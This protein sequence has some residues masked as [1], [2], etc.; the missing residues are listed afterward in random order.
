[1][2]R[3]KPPKLALR[4]LTIVLWLGSALPL[5]ANTSADQLYAVAA[6][7]YAQGEWESAAESFARFLSNQPADPRSPSAEYYRGECFVQLQH[8][9]EA[10]AIFERFLARHPEHPQVI[11][12]RFRAGEVAYRLGDQVKAERYLAEFR[13]ESAGHELEAFAVPH[14]AAMALERGDAARAAELYSFALQTFPRGPLAAECRLGVATAQEKLGNL[15][16]ARRFYRVAALSRDAAVATQAQLRLAI[17][18][19]REDNFLAALEL[20]E[21]LPEKINDPALLSHVALWK[22]RSLDGLGRVREAAE[23]WWEVVERRPDHEISESLAY[24]AAGA[25][26][27]VGDMPR[28]QQAYRWLSARNPTG[29]W[30]EESLVAQI[31]ILLESERLMPR[32]SEVERNRQEDHGEEGRAAEI[33]ALWHRLVREFPESSRREP[34]LQRLGHQL[35]RQGQY[36]VLL[37]LLADSGEPARNLSREKTAPPAGTDSSGA[38]ALATPV[39][40]T[41]VAS[42]LV[43]YLSALAH[44]GDGHHAAALQ[45]LEPWSE[46][47]WPAGMQSGAQRVR[48]NCLIALRRFDDAIPALEDELRHQSTLNSVRDR[49]LQLALALSEVGRLEEAERVL[50]AMWQESSERDPI[51]GDGHKDSRE[52]SETRGKVLNCQRGL[53]LASEIAEQAFTARQYPLAARL[54][55]R[56]A[57]QSQDNRQA[58]EARLGWSWALFQDSQLTEAGDV[59]DALL[60]IRDVSPE[61]GEARASGKDDAPRLPDNGLPGDARRDKTTN[62]D[63]GKVYAEAAY[64][65]AR[66][67]ERREERPEAVRR[68]QLV[69]DL[70]PISRFAADSLFAAGRLQDRNGATAEAND[71][72]RRLLTEF[73]QYARADAARYL[74]GLGSG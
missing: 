17:L 10:L 67:H 73:P 68:Y 35:L 32:D 64:L 11:R 15:S 39:R 46:S 43:R 33:I 23:I 65:R 24:Q 42:P 71:L 51:S 45:Q 26:Q 60:A 70:D 1:M 52:T 22:G 20:L 8:Y 31:E 44:L 34:T 6:A 50:E 13:R 56:V 9:R 16:E 61:P 25:F 41:P 63:L 72:L 69:L 21:S 58:V 74:R 36:S 2:E 7:H 55:R 12:A 38:H 18:L 57:D 54:F 19:H 62:G 28:A 29:P 37:Q 3:Y 47:D 27:R 53:S 59:L 49:Q 14:L 30:A 5:S 4:W 40:N 66:I 48:V